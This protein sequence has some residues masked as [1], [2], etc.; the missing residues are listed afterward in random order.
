MITYPQARK[1]IVLH[2]RRLPA[3]ITSLQESAGGVI[4][5][6][7]RSP[8]NQPF[9]DNCAM[10]GF[11]LHAADTVHASV[12]NP[13]RLEICGSLRAGSFKKNDL[14]RG[15]VFR[16]MTGAPIP[17]GADAVIEKENV[18]VQ[19]EVL[20]V[21]GPV[22]KGRHIRY[23]G[24]EITRGAR[25]DLRETVVTPGVIGFL[26][27]LG[28]K[29]IQVYK[30]PRVSL[31]ATGDELVSCGGKL[32]RGQIYDSNTPM[33][34]AALA[35]LSITPGSVRR[36]ADRKESLKVALSDVIQQSNVV[37]L[38][39]GVSVGDY[40]HAKQVFKEL[41]VKSIFWKVLQKP[42]KPVFFG[43]MGGVL[44]FGLPGNPAAVFTCFYEY[45]YPA[46]RLSMGYKN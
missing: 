14:K 10:D 38:T 43:K 12:K 8:I 36:V 44:V 27:G 26:S 2:S 5:S 11:A 39:G 17:A 20:M 16:I 42:G 41:G 22:S 29:K 37:I 3:V 18:L 34:L 1:E 21:S 25:I 33:L 6:D 23:R 35:S 15:K 46:V 19:D 7:A 40:D 13:T 45:V 32:G 28:I 9:F 24:E 30:K 4:A 31:V